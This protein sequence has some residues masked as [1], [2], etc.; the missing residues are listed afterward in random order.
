MTSTPRTRL[1][2]PW[3]SSLRRALGTECNELARPEDRARS[4][5]ELLAALAAGL[6]F[7][8]G[9]TAAW[10]DFNA[11]EHRTTAAASRLHRLDAVLLT[12]A[13]PTTDGTDPA[14]YRA[15][16]AWT[17]PAGQ[18]QTGTVG[19]ARRAPAGATTRI[20]VGDTG[21]P[22]ATPPA[23]ADL[24]AGAACVGL[25]VLGFLSVLIAVG[26][27]LRVNTLDR[28][29]ATAWQRRWAEVEPVWSGRAARRPNTG[30]PRHG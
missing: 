29:T 2:H 30:D 5:A 23:T 11:A 24:V 27:E 17:F 8:L 15:T 20:W 28:R 22:A 18:G 6:A 4:R 26:L 13:R 25:L 12:P 3:R 9:T 1:T 10:T 7:L 16:A 19:V 14:R 21:R